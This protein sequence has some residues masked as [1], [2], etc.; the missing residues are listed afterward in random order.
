[1][2]GYQVP[3][4]QPALYNPTSHGNLFYLLLPWLH[5]K[6]E[7]KQ[8]NKK[9][10]CDSRYFKEKLSVGKEAMQGFAG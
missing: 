2:R 10:M 8:T 7:N 4:P 3:D 9:N 1:M 5:S 6:Q